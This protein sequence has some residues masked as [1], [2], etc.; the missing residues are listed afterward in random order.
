LATSGETKDEAIDNLLEAIEEYA[1]D[2]LD[3]LDIFVKSPNRGSHLT[4]ILLIASCT[5]KEDM[6]KLF[7]ITCDIIN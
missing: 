3:R 6:L 2:Y 7:N 1:E 5:S 4:Y